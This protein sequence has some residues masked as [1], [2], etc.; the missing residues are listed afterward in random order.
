MVD[1]V[2]TKRLRCFSVLVLLNEL[3]NNVFAHIY[4]Y[5]YHVA[6]KRAIIYCICCLLLCTA[7][8]KD[9]ADAQKMME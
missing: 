9:I 7:M 5:A 2:C 1:I 8:E 4:T 3:H 6:N